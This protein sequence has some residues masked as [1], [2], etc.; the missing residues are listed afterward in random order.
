[1]AILYL[2]GELNSCQES[3][4]DFFSLN[5]QCVLGSSPTDEVIVALGTTNNDIQM[6]R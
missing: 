4:M 2:P 3:R 5:F 6:S 1:M